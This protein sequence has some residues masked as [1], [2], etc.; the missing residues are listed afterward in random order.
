MSLK[1]SEGFLP[2]CER[3]VFEDAG[4]TVARDWMAFVVVKADVLVNV[5]MMTARRRAGKMMLRE[6]IA[7]VVKYVVTS[8]RFGVVELISLRLR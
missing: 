7:A 2:N 8:L 5:A 3:A 4:A 1:S 6:N